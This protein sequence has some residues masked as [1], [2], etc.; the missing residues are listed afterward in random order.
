MAVFF[1]FVYVE[2]KQEVISLPPT[3]EPCTMKTLSIL[4]LVAVPSIV[5]G[6]YIFN[7]LIVNGKSIGGEYVLPHSFPSRFT[8]STKHNILFK[9][10]TPNLDTRTPARTAI[11]TTPPSPPNSSPPRT[12]AATRAPRPVPSQNPTPSPPATRSVSSS[13]TTSSSNTPAPASSTCPSPPP[14]RP[15]PAMMAPA[16]GSSSGRVVCARAVPAKTAT[17]V[18]GRKIASR[19]RCREISRLESIWLGWSILGYMRRRRGGR[20]FT[21]GC[22]F[23]FLFSSFSLFLIGL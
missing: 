6:H 17:G 11:P 23:F 16:T 18:C 13:S 9:L 4:A 8:T 15:S 5:E 7:R 14:A 3:L 1:S 12:S 21:V 19:L 22:S 10:T 20:S 2:R